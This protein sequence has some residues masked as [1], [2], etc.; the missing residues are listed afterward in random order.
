MFGLNP[1]HLHKSFLGTTIPV[2]DRCR[3][4]RR[5]RGEKCSG[6]GCRIARSEPHAPIEMLDPNQVEHGHDLFGGKSL[7]LKRLQIR[8]CGSGGVLRKD[9]AV[10]PSSIYSWQ[11]GAVS[12]AP[13]HQLSSC[14]ATLNR[15]STQ[16]QA[17]R[18]IFQIVILSRVFEAV[19][20]ATAQRLSIALLGLKRRRRQR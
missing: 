2:V 20:I 11:A 3:S 10:L 16:H 15:S 17:P 12:T 6:V 4:K 19:N 9:G 7:K 14:H 13:S 5:I 18:A 1:T 8:S